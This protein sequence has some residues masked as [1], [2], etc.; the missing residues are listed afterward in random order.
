MAKLTDTCA[1]ITDAIGPDGKPDE[2]LTLH[3]IFCPTRQWEHCEYKNVCVDGNE[4]VWVPC[5]AQIIV[6]AEIDMENSTI[7]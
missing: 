6:Q 7:Q 1:F 3:R 4:H 2:L 5:P